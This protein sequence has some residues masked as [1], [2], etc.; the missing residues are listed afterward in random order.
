MVAMK[1]ILPH[2]LPLLLAAFRR[3]IYLFGKK[4]DLLRNVTH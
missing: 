2:T 3:T 4:L 1:Y